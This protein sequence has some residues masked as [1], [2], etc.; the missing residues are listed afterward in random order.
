MPKWS[1]VTYKEVILLTTADRL[2]KFLKNMLMINKNKLDQ[3]GSCYK[4]PA[5][6]HIRNDINA[7]VYF[8]PGN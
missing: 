2:A 6:W 8:K 1:A 5:Y 3:I 4:H 7:M